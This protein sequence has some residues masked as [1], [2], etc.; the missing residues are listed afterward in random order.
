MVSPHGVPVDLLDRLVIIRTQARMP[1]F[2]AAT[3]RRVQHAS[4]LSVVLCACLLYRLAIIR[5]QAGSAAFLTPPTSTA[6]L[7]PPSLCPINSLQPYTLEE[8]VQILAIRAQ[9]FVFSYCL[10]LILLLSSPTNAAGGL[11][12]AAAPVR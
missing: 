12:A 5:T 6:F 7:M 4:L 11:R 8:M 2:A 3:I 9:V 10:N 1:G